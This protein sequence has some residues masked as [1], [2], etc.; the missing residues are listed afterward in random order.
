MSNTHFS[1]SSLKKPKV[2][3]NKTLITLNR[4]IP[5]LTVLAVDSKELIFPH[6]CYK[7]CAIYGVVSHP[8]W[9]KT[10]FSLQLETL[11]CT[12]TYTFVPKILQ[13]SQIKLC[14]LYMLVVCVTCLSVRSRK[15]V[16]LWNGPNGFYVHEKF[17]FLE[18][19][20]Q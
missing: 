13:H 5:I 1:N 8:Y 14:H 10:T 9:A 19:R 20:C 2:P 15:V 18:S 17:F 11:R 3:K 12:Y 4:S 7:V 6:K 16:D